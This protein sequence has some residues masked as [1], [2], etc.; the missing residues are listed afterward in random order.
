MLR[1]A[2]RKPTEADVAF[3]LSL[4][5][6][7]GIEPELLL[8]IRHDEHDH[9]EAFRTKLRLAIKE[10]LERTDEP[11]AADVAL[12]I[13]RDVIDPALNDIE[14]RLKA[15]RKLMQRKARLNLGLGSLVTSCGVL[16]ANPII[17]GAGVAAMIGTSVTAG[18]KYLEEKRD[19]ALSDMYFLWHTKRH[20]TEGW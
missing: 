4:P 2:K 19:I 9:F 12:E 3:H 8:R 7:E 17:T 13:R 11:D 6:L 15:A 10:R 16:T 20:A 18:N 5:I 1:A 14:R